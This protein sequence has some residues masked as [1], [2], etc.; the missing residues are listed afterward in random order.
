MDR[1]IRSQNVEHFIQ[2]LK[3]ATDPSERERLEGL[4]AEERQ[5]QKDAGEMPAQST[6][7]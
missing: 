7:R 5:K 1:F 2:L 4:L 6:A 3:T